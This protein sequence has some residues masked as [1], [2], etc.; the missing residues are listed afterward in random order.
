MKCLTQSDLNSTN[1]PEHS[2]FAPCLYNT[3]LINENETLYQ[4]IE[5][6]TL[7]KLDNKKEDGLIKILK[8]NDFEIIGERLNRGKVNFSNNIKQADNYEIFSDNLSLKLISFNYDRSESKMSYFSEEEIINILKYQ[9]IDFIK[10]NN[11]IQSRKRNISKYKKQN[12]IY[13]YC[14]SYFLL[15]IELILLRSWNI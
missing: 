8:N 14:L 9:K 5:N 13:F 10:N 12:I 3:A 6:Q 7:I 1:F 2:L 4:K 11:N 15:L